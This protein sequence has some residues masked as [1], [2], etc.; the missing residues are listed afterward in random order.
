[1]IFVDEEQ[2]KVFLYLI[3]QKAEI[4]IT[5]SHGSYVYLLFKHFTQEK[6][7]EQEQSSKAEHPKRNLF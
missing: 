1:M 6:T 4:Y 5:S 2:N 7:V 3:T